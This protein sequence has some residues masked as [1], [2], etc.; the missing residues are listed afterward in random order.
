MVD[1]KQLDVVL[2]RY[3]HASSTEFDVTC[4]IAEVCRRG[5]DPVNFQLILT[6]MEI[7]H[8]PVVGWPKSNTKVSF[9]RLAVTFVCCRWPPT[10]SSAGHP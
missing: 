7:M 10:V 1:A 9:P 2:T 5:I 8:M 4:T 6:G 3:R